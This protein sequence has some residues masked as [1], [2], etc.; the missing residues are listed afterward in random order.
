[1]KALQ[2]ELPS[3]QVPTLIATLRGRELSPV[4]RLFQDQARVVAASLV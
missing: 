3:W 2:I 4:A 1:M